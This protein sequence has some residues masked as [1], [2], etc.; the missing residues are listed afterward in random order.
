MIEDE[1]LGVENSPEDVLED[2]EWWAVALEGFQEFCLFGISGGSAEATEVEG[3]DHGAGVL[4]FLE[5]LANHP[6]VA[7]AIVHRIAIE[8]VQGLGEVGFHLDL[9]GT[10]RLP[11]GTTEGGEEVGGGVSIRYLDGSRSEGKS[12]EL[13]GR[14]SDLREGVE[15]DLGAQTADE[16][17]RKIGKVLFVGLVRA[18]G[19]LVGA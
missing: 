3:L 5:K 18:T 13:V 17:V 12:A 10:D 1:F 8:Q 2:F 4:V 16:G 19:E 15:E 9:A 11:G 6:A 7:H 14:L